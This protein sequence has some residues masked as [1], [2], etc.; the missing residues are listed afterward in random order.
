M[1]CSRLKRGRVRVPPC[2]DRKRFPFLPDPEDYRGV[3]TTNGLN[4]RIR[5]FKPRDRDAKPE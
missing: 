2:L 3:S 1:D 5:T 4:F